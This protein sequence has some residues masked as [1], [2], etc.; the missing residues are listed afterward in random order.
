[1]SAHSP[2]WAQ[3]PAKI[4]YVY[5]NMRPCVAARSNGWFM[6]TELWIVYVRLISNLPNSRK[7]SFKPRFSTNKWSCMANDRNHAHLIQL[8]SAIYSEVSAQCQLPSLLIDNRAW[9]R[10]KS[11]VAAA[12]I[13]IIKAAW[14]TYMGTLLR[15]NVI[16]IPR[17]SAH[18]QILTQCKVHSPWALF[19]EGMVI[20]CDA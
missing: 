15:L 11:M 9:I 18:P 13:W 1:M 2:L 6:R 4:Q 17:I 7:T 14:A 19:R 8:L 12:I 3:F 10:L 20:Y 16:L 5:L